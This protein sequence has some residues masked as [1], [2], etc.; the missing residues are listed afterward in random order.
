MTASFSRV[1][2]DKVHQMVAEV[3]KVAKLDGIFYDVTNK[4]PGTI[5][6]E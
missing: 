1:P 6:W 4:P 2:M 5:E 3:R